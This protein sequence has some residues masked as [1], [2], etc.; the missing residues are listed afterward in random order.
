M[1][2]FWVTDRFRG[3]FTDSI[4]SAKEFYTSSGYSVSNYI[5]LEALEVARCTRWVT[6]QTS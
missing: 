3:L 2:L 4:P 1:Q 6:G 5:C